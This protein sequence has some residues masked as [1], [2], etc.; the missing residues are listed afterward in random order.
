MHEL[1]YRD[2]V[3]VV[4]EEHSCPMYYVG[5]TFT[6]HNLSIAVSENK[7]ACLMMTQ[8]L[9]KATADLKSVQQQAPLEKIHRKKFECDGCIGFICFERKKEKSGIQICCDGFSPSKQMRKEFAAE[10]FSFFRDMELFEPLDDVELHKLALLM[11]VHEYSLKKKIITVG[12]QGKNLYIVLSGQVVVVRRDNRIIAELGPSDI[13]GEMSLLARG[14]AYATVYSKTSTRVASLNEKDFKSILLRHSVLRIFLY[15]LQLERAQMNAILSG[16]IA[17]GMGGELTFINVVEVFQLINNGGKSG[18]VDFVLPDSYASVLF[19]EGEIIYASY[20]E[21][22]GKEAL[23]A[24]LDK[25]DG[26][27]TYT[28][29]LAEE[30]KDMPALGEFIGLMLKG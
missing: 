5:D 22:L 18:R 3:F 29:G 10:F 4:T 9:L 26:T 8:E 15:R 28:S 25:S 21:L 11:N 16:Q 1:S 7:Q 23:F 6:I 2:A 13:F 12:K 24:L 30:F 14:P 27:F 20:G 19:K 17:S